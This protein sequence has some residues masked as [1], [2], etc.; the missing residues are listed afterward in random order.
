MFHT[1]LRAHEGCN[2]RALV[3]LYCSVFLAGHW[4]Y[5][6]QGFGPRLWLMELAGFFWQS[7]FFLVT[8][9]NLQTLLATCLFI[10]LDGC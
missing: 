2:Q 5:L 8:F 4:F 6:C 7:L 9:L 10:R 3:G 1:F